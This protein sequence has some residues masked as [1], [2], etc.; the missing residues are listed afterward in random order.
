M[1]RIPRGRRRSNGQCGE[2]AV[3]RTHNTTRAAQRQPDG[4]GGRIGWDDGN[5]EGMKNP[6]ECLSPGAGT[7]RFAS[8]G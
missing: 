1:G 8:P 3:G 4:G 6:G 5:G 7:F 2:K